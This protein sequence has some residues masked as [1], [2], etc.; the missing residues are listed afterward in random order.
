MYSIPKF[1]IL[2]LL[3]FI[4]FFLFIRAYH[5]KN[6]SLNF[7]HGYNAEGVD[8]DAPFYTSKSAGAH[9]H[10]GHGE[11]HG[12]EGEHHGDTNN[13]AT[14]QEENH[15]TENVQHS[16]TSDST[17]HS[18]TSDSTHKEESHTEEHQN[19]TH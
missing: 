5:R 8:I 6:T 15:S 11:E 19:E 13:H 2:I 16:N 3:L 4:G 12:T 17:N 14:H 9:G 18:N 10:G 7:S 1:R